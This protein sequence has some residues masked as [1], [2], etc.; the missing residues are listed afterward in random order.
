MILA[1]FCGYLAL[2]SFDNLSFQNNIPHCVF[3][4]VTG[5]PCPGCGMGR[6]T[7]ELFS[8]NILNSFRYNILCFPFTLMI[9]I[10]LFWMFADIVKKK[11][12]FFMFINQNMKK[13]YKFLLFAIVII[14][15][16]VNIIREI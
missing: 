6:S 8:G 7:I 1:I 3:K 2:F 14:N 5:I 13:K 4:L 16:T 10:S 11:E 12:T 15:W 9:I